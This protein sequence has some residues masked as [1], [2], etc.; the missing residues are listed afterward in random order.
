MAAD[1]FVVD[2]LIH[3]VKTAC[4]ALTNAAVRL[5]TG[6]PEKRREVLS[7]MIPRAQRLVDLLA[8]YKPE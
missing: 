5:R 2:D 7:L 4:S 8:A 1:D 3:D 6:T